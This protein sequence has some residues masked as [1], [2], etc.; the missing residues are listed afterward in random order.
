MDK[1][2][3]KYKE[4]Y[5]LSKEAF[6]EEL[7]RFYR[8]DEK[9]SRYFTM[10]T[11]LIG[12]SLFFGKW[13]TKSILPPTCL[14]EWSIFILCILVFIVFISSWFK[15]MNAIKLHSLSKIPLDYN[16]IKF[17]SDNRLIDIYYAM[18]KGMSKE[19]L[20]N[21]EINDEKSRYLNDTYRRMYVLIFL[22]IFIT[23]LF[24]IKSYN[25]NIAI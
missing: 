21:R 22:L 1:N 17:F 4:L 10:L 23:I 12:A 18:S 9:A 15:L 7:H 25:N 3:E 13:L 11:L 20:V 8:L 5:T 14:I 19:I 16:S 6:N 2:L 24:V